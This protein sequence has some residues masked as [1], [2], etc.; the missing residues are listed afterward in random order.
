MKH[1]IAGMTAAVALSVMALPSPAPS[2]TF[3]LHFRPYCATDDCGHGTRALFEN[4]VCRSVQELNLE[5]ERAGISFRPT[6]APNQATAPSGGVSG[7]PSEKN[8]YAELNVG[9]ACNDEES[10][11]YALAEAWRNDVAAVNPGEISYLLRSGRNWNCSRFP[12]DALPYGIIGDAAMSR[13]TQAAGAV[14]AHEIGHYF[15][16]SHT[17]TGQDP[18]THSPV[19]HDGDVGNANQGLV[20]VNDTPDD[21]KSRENCPKFCGGNSNAARCSDNSDC[22]GSTTCDRVCTSGHD[23]DVN[24]S[25]VDGHDWIAIMNNVGVGD[26]GSPHPDSC[27]PTLLRRASG[28]TIATFPASA[29]AHNSMSYYGSDCVG[30]IIIGGQTLEPYSVDQIARMHDSRSVYAARDANNLPDVC[31]TRGGDSDDDGICDYDDSC[32]YVRNLCSQDMDGDGDQIPDGCDN[33]PGTSNQGQSDLDGD[34]E[35]D[36]C[37]ADDDGDGCFDEPGMYPQDQHPDSAFAKIGEFLFGPF[38][39]GSSDKNRMGFEGG[40][41]DTDSDGV[42]DCADYDDDDDGFCDDAETLDST[43]PGVGADGCTGPDPCRLIPGENGLACLKYVDCPKQT[44]WDVCL[45]GGC[46]EMLLKFTSLINPDPTSVLVFDKFEIVN[47]TI[48]AQPSTGLTASQSAANI[49]ALAG[50]GNQVLLL[51]LDAISAASEEERF[52]VEIWRRSSSGKEERLRVVGEFD[53]SSLHLGDVTAG[54]FVR[55]STEVDRKTRAERLVVDTA[56]AVGLEPTV[57][58]PDVDLDGL[59]DLV[60][61]CPRD[62]NATQADADRDGY[63][64][65]CDPDLDNDGKVSEADVRHV[66]SCYGAD[67]TQQLPSLCAT[68]GVDSEPYLPSEASMALARWCRSADVSGDGRVDAVDHRLVLGAL[69]REMALGAGRGE[70]LRPAPGC[71]GPASL[72]KARLVLGRLN[73]EGGAHS[74]TISGKAALPSSAARVDPALRGMRVLVR[75]ASGRSVVDA[76]VPEGEGWVRRGDRRMV[77]KSDTQG[78]GIRKVVLKQVGDDLKVRVVARNGSFATSAGELPLSV[79]LTFD[80]EA[81]ATGQCTRAVFG[82]AGERAACLTVGDGAKVLCR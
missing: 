75:T 71:V 76:V 55:I 12:W 64:D 62:A 40:G 14:F 4:F 32:R 39:T 3:D 49:G 19:N 60:D 44:W 31:A 29:Q 67:L 17:F 58:L 79:E 18:A 81:A 8:Q 77:Y 42:P 65:R 59:V 50:V 57:D 54:R 16:L 70:A 48:Y 30:P 72:G 6:I 35:G 22:M 23:E 11:D 80:T 10:D 41:I 25:P 46:D 28:Q 47:Q 68:E 51:Q 69:G 63:G 53:A 61:N 43:A 24:G 20:Y 82:P 13:G 66:E 45:F 34:G 36:A 7:Q 74:M 56:P 9:S 2:A 27:T 26:P 38:C 37:D 73:R 52:L 15:A 78:D 21:A 1:T 5:Y 33:C